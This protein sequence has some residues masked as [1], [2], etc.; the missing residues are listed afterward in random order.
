MN[1]SPLSVADAAIA[2]MAGLLASYE[3]RLY[4]LRRHRSEHLW[5]AILCVVTGG[6]ATSMA[7]HYDAGAETA[8]VLSR[9]EGVLLGTAA[10]AALAL[11]S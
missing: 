2:G 7:I 1:V 4:A 5:L 10:H 9:L 8:L 6:Y 11:Q 3:A